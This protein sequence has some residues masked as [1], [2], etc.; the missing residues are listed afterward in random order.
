MVSPRPARSPVVSTRATATTTPAPVVATP[1]SARTPSPTGDTVKCRWVVYGGSLLG[2]NDDLLADVS[3][4]ITTRFFSLPGG[5][6]NATDPF[7]LDASKKLPLFLISL[8]WGSGPAFSGFLTKYDD[9]LFF[10]APVDT[11]PQAILCVARRP[12][13][14]RD[15]TLPYRY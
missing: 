8:Q 12:E 5:E 13:Y 7:G 1:G 4:S 2:E 10:P 3:I 15:G 6:L 14:S 9:F 11:R